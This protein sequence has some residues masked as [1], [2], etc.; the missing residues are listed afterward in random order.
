MGITQ[1]IVA[2]ELP[3]DDELLAGNITAERQICEVAFVSS[4]AAS[5]EVANTTFSGNCAVGGMELGRP[6]GLLSDTGRGGA[7]WSVGSNLT[8]MANTTL[9][10]N[11]ASAGGAVSSEAGNLTLGDC[12]LQQNLA[13]KYGGAVTV[14]Q[15]FAHFVHGTSFLNNKAQVK[16]YSPLYKR[17]GTLD[18]LPSTITIGHPACTNSVT[19]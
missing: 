1:F 7:V 5:V 17:R 6:L 16:C 11:G 12:L 14:W 8:L 18:A 2:T 13:S 15:G 4:Q 3:S 19:S 10:S 9:D